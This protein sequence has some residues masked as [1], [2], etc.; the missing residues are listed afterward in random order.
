MVTAKDIL[1]YISSGSE[2][3]KNIKQNALGAIAIKIIAMGIQLIQV[4]IVL[5]YLEPTLYGVYLTITSIVV[6]THN[7]DFGLGSGLRYK[8][9]EAL[10]QN[11]LI[12]GRVLVSTA[13]ISLSIIML[14]VGLCLI[15]IVPIFNWSEILNCK[16]LSNGYLS[17]CI[18]IV[19]ATLL[20]QF[21]LELVT[22]VLQA[23]QRAAISTIFKPLSN[24]IAVLGVLFLKTT[25]TQSLL[26]ACIVL[27]MPLVLVLFLTNIILFSK[28]YRMIAPNIKFYRKEAVKDIYSLGLKFF[29]SSLSGI[30]VYNSTS[31]IISHY[32]APSE[33]TTYS[34]AYTYFSLFIVFHGVFLTPI[35]AAITD[36]WVKKD[37]TWLKTCMRKV[38]WLTTAFSL[39]ILMGLCLSEFAFRI[40]VGNRV[41]IPF[42]LSAWLSIYFIMNLWS[43]TYNCFVV[44][45]GK[46]Q[47]TMYLSLFKIVAF[48]PILIGSITYFGIIGVVLVTIAVNTVPN[49]LLGYI[50]YHMLINKQAKGIWNK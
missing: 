39:L 45:V 10:A 13:Y 50:Q 44:G 20:T 16:G 18:I 9:T 7:F 38:S 19:L 32:I 2:R 43:A 37:Y 42:T 27:T 28:R 6:W 1:K 48:I 49:V 30:V 21:V 35:W 12:R 29:V 22:I 17:L 26:G 33:V 47:L 40:W 5:S 46:A 23:N 8:L 41:T 31:I 24:V 11:D 3:S 34:I 25:E 14:V 15:P 4:P 36:S